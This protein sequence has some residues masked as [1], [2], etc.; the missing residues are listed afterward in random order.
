MPHYS[1][2][3]A[4]APERDRRSFQYAGHYRSSHQYS[5]VHLSLD[6]ALKHFYSK[7]N[8]ATVLLKKGLLD[9]NNLYLLD[10]A[11]VDVWANVVWVKIPKWIQLPNVAILQKAPQHFCRFI[12]KK[13]FLEAVID[14]AQLMGHQSK[15]HRCKSNPT[16]ML[17]QS[18]TGSGVYQ[19]NTTKYACECD[20]SAFL[21]LKRAYTEDCYLRGLINRHPILQGQLPDKHVFCVWAS[22]GAKD[23]RH[24]QYEQGRR[25]LSSFGL[26]LD[27]IIPGHFTVY[28]KSRKLGSVDLKRDES[29]KEFWINQ[30]QLTM[31]RVVPGDRIGYATA[32]EAAIALAQLLKVIDNGSLAK[33]D[34]FGGGWDEQPQ[35]LIEPHADFIDDVNQE[36]TPQL[37]TASQSMQKQRDP[38]GGFSF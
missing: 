7:S 25:W 20:C 21:G 3:D 22:W 19:L 29:G 9:F 38:F 37:V 33:A 12:S 2:V 32:E 15:A 11:T 35:H 28:H 8:L 27:Y 4:I 13:D 1:T 31:L 6:A 36:S 34:L 26:S 17:V 24:Y 16:K 5:P 14:Y 10:H 30:R 23:F 18:S